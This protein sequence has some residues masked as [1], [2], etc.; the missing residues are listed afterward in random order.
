MD[1]KPSRGL[2]RYF[3]QV[4]DPRAANVSFSLKSL[5]TM[6]LLAV[7][8]RCDDY[9]EIACW[10]ERRADWLAGFVDLP[11]G[12]HGPRTPHADTFERVFR[13]IKPAAMER[14]FIAFTEGLAEAS[15]GRLV[16]I[17]GKTLRGSVDLGGRKAA[18][19][20]VHAWDQHNHLVLGQLAVEEKSNEIT[21][22]PKLLELLDVKGAVVSLDAMHCQKNTA[23]AIRKA[24]ADYLLA[25]KD[26]QK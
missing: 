18:I 26:N 17:D 15:A 5:L 6:T 11:T 3:D 20:M 8:C 9:E 7:L 13:R 1:V 10:A 16:A 2:L 23:T 19:H 22:V 12:E 25:V 21:A 4:P 24:G 14:V